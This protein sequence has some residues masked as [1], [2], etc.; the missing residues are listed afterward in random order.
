MVGSGMATSG[1]GIAARSGSSHRGQRTRYCTGRSTLRGGLRRRKPRR[2]NRASGRRTFRYPGACPRSDNHRSCAHRLD[3]DF[4]RTGDGGSIRDTVYAAV[5]LV[6]NGIVGLCLLAGGV[7]HRKQGFQFQ[8]AN[9]ALSVLIALTSL[10]LVLPNITITTARGTYSPSQLIFAGAASLILYGSFLLVQT[11]RH[12]DY[13]LSVGGGGEE[14]H[15][16]PPTNQVALASSGLLLLSLVAIVGLAKVLTPML[17][18]FIEGVGAPRT[19]VGIL[20]AGVVL[21]P[22]GLAAVRAA[23]ANRIQTSMNLAMGSVLATVGLTIPATVTVALGLGR[24][25]TLGVGPTE[26]ALLMLTL[27]VSLATLGT[28]RTTVLQG[29][30]HL[31]ILAAFL[32]FSIVP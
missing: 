27:I 22:E 26:L 9:A 21:L 14:I 24:P 28:G 2:G 29:I 6:C 15:A 31:V 19:V 23:R 11:V 25:L 12:R 3:H 1:F 5:M 4:R 18:R 10:T 7:R 16:S 8:G 13:F 32:F 17:E 20:I 30:V